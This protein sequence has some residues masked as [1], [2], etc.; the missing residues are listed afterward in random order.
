MNGPARSAA[1]TALLVLMT[2]ACAGAS[3]TADAGPTPDAVEDART[4]DVDDGPDAADAGLPPGWSAESHAKGSPAAYGRIFDD[5]RVQRLDVT[6]PAATYAA[7]LAEL[8]ANLGEPGTSTPGAGTQ[9]TPTGPPT[10]AQIAACAGRE[11]GDPC[12][13]SEQGQEVTGTCKA[14]PIPDKPAACAPT[15]PVGGG[16]DVAFDPS[17]VDAT[18]RYDGRE[19]RHVALRFKG[20]SSLRDPWRW[21]RTKLSLRLNFD[22]LEDDHPEIEDQRFWGFKKLVL[23][24]NWRD[25]SLLR[26]KLASE[27]F[28]AHGV[29]TARTAFYEVHVD[30]GEGPVYWGLY[31]ALED[32]SDQL[33]DDWFGDGD[34][35][36]Y[37]ANGA[38]ADWTHFDASGFENQTNDDADKAEVQAAIAALQADRTDATAWRSGL[39]ARFDVA[40]F[41]KFLAANTVLQNWDTYGMAPHNY[42]LYAEPDDPDRLKWLAT[43]LNEALRATG[44]PKPLPGLSLADV[45]DDWPLIRYVLDDATYA[46]AYRAEVQAFAEGPF[47]ADALISRMEALH[48]LI[49]PSVAAER[50]PFTLL[51]SPEAF[52]TSLDTGTDALKPH[53]LARHQAVQ[54]FLGAER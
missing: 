16:G 10:Q 54:A 21:G 22:K 23:N 46:A 14:A 50:T 18:V 39:E 6:L 40:L 19:W 38:G 30:V 45:G 34:G 11:A 1:L 29:P 7:M 32:P 24:N 2:C 47:A 26:E 27:L 5:G 31:T 35:N 9:P 51:E 20:N 48:A 4:P 15:G 12:T 13:Y 17:W 28:R 41:L 49:A 8:T 42:L 33:L 36:L 37:E 52:A 43:D 53:V 3:E 44:T 25:P